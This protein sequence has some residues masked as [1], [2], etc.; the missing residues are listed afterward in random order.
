MQCFENL[1]IFMVVN[2]IS[3]GSV[4]VTPIYIYLVNKYLD[5]S[6]G[7]RIKIL[8]RCKIIISLCWDRYHKTAW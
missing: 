4:R 3:Q 6:I 8:S 1:H 5:G 2:G 7:Q